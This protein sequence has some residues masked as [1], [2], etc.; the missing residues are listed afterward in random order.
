MCACDAAQYSTDQSEAAG[1]DHA[2]DER[3]KVVV[4][5]EHVRVAA[6]LPEHS[7]NEC[8]IHH[9]QQR[10]TLG[11]TRLGTTLVRVLHEHHVHLPHTHSSLR[12]VR[13][14]VCL[15]VTSSVVNTIRQCLN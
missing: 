15:S 1:D 13:L 11:R 12:S 3:L 14:S 6:Q 2:D 5:N 9:C 4:F 8:V 7:T 10:R